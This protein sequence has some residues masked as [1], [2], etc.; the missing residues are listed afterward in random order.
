MKQ[1]IIIIASIVLLSA[2]SPEPGTE[3]WCAKMKEKPKSEW[4]A[5]EAGTYTK[6]CLID[7]TATDSQ[8]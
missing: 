3:K 7:G 1:L 8:E 5:S 6:N 2:C 4:T